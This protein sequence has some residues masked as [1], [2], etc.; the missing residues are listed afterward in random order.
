[1]V[2]LEKRDYMYSLLYGTWNLVGK[3]LIAIFFYSYF[4]GPVKI[5]VLFVPEIRPNL[6]LS[7]LLGIVSCAAHQI[8]P[9]CF[10]G[11]WYRRM[12]VS[13]PELLQQLHLSG[14]RCGVPLGYISFTNLDIYSTLTSYSFLFSSKQTNVNFPGGKLVD[15]TAATEADLQNELDKVK[16]IF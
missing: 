10:G 13:N 1:M 14:R 4:C 3:T 8:L 7:T 6:F 12:L 16:L 15:A 11:C 5:F 2:A 9:Y